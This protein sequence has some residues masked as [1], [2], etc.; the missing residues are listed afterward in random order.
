MGFESRLTLIKERDQVRA[1]VVNT[2]LRS[3]DNNVRYLLDLINAA[4]VGSTLYLRRVTVEAEAKVGMAVY[5]SEANARFERAM[6]QADVDATTGA[7]LTT[8]SSHVWGVVKEKINSTLAD[9]LVHGYETLDIGQAVDG[10]VA[11]GT[12]Y[13]SGTNPG[14]LVRQ[15]P[16]VSV[17]VLRATGDGKVLVNPQWLDA[18]DRHQH[19]RFELVCAPAGR[20][21]TPSPGDHHQVEG[22]ADY[23]GWL[24][25]DHFA[26]KAPAGARFGYNLD[27]HPALKNAWPPLP[28]NMA[29][30]VWNKGAD[31]SVGGTTVPL[32]PAGLAVVDH[33]GIWWMSDCYGDVPW[34]VQYESH[35]SESSS[36]SASTGECPRALSMSLVLWFSKATFL[37]EDAAVLSLYS[38][39][40]KLQVVCRGTDTPATSGNLELKLN[41]DFSAEG[42]TDGY[43]VLKSFDAETSRFRA[44]N[45]CEGVY[46]LSSNVQLTGDVRAKRVPGDSSSEDLFQGKVGISVTNEADVEL[47]V[48]QV[49]LSGA[50]QSFFQDTMYFGFVPAEENEYR[51]KV[52]VPL[53]LT[54]P[55]PQMKLVF[56]VFGRAAGTL[57]QLTVTARRIPRPADGLDEPQALPTSD[58]EFAVAIDTTGTLTSTNQYVEAESQP[59]DVEAGDTVF[60]TVRRESTDSYNAEVGIL[61]HAA[62]VESGA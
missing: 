47:D 21:E 58:D 55:S 14:K 59:F 28:L 24:P 17:A 11:A 26:G 46:A 37:T 15:R 52:Q 49:R 51:A 40:R 20:H 12:Y 8:D 56:H 42:N 54:T 41:L 10:A 27:M 30:L 45:V 43:S 34:P 1:G 57:P 18:L 2:P 44:G 7:V 50:E 48:T 3:L 60:F 33:N 4:S 19:Y 6:A 13:L 53:G 36:S 38:A 22:D 23:A 29:E 31:A 35:V 16:P 62:V 39:D 5:Y 32:G 9:V 25:A 61:R